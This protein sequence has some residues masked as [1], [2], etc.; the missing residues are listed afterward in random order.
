[1]YNYEAVLT[2]ICCNSYYITHSC[3]LDLIFFILHFWVKLTG[4]LFFVQH[5][6]N[7]AA[8][9]KWSNFGQIESK[10][11]KDNPEKCQEHRQMS[12][13]SPVWTFPEQ[14]KKLIDLFLEHLRMSVKDEKDLSSLLSRLFLFS[15]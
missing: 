14:K 8:L 15:Y 4:S 10:L 6:L 12:M 5:C 1:M 7:A 9:F 2:V 3:N 13:H 11:Q